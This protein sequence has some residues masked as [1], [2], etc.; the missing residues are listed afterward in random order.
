MPTPSIRANRTPPDKKKW[1][2]I[3]F[4]SFLIYK[5]KQYYGF[6]TNVS[7]TCIKYKHEYLPIKI[8]KLV[9]TVVYIT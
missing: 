8:I 6:C 3:M 9:L 2:F 5:I 7:K 4:V 1:T